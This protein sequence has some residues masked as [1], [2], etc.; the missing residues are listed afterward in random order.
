MEQGV[1]G[2]G[3]TTLGKAIAEALSLPFIDADDIHSQANRDKMTR[4]EPLTDADRGPWLVNVRKAAVQ[5][6]E[7][8]AWSGVV[9]A[10]SALKTSY[11]EVLRGTRAHLASPAQKPRTVFV[12]PFG[13]RSELLE[14]VAGREGHFMKAN[15]LESQFDTLENPAGTG[16][17]G[18]VGVQLEMGPEEQVQAAL[19]GLRTIGAI[20]RR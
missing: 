8:N 2:S 11:R 5:A 7:G 6:L 13:R 20:E 10:C 4:G 16:E 19:D 18:V 14:R 12:H 3:K 15:M 17:E 9:V 1:S